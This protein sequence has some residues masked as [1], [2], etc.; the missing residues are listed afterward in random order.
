[1]N[2]KDYLTGPVQVTA[3]RINM[4]AANYVYAVA[5][6]ATKASTPILR[7][8]MLRRVEIVAGTLLEATDRFHYVPTAMQVGAA[9][10]V[11]EIALCEKAAAGA[12]NID[13]WMTMQ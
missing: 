8:D 13:A 7:D 9:L 5:S 3:V 10:T 6:T 4:I 11:H 12:L 2:I 1:M